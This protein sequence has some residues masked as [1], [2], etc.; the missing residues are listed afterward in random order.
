VG[1][2]AH[3]A[4]NAA[5]SLL[6]TN[7]RHR[8]QLREGGP[9]AA[10]DFA[11]RLLPLRLL[12]QALRHDLCFCWFADA[13]A[14]HAV[15]AFHAVGKP[16]VIVPGQYE[17]AWEPEAEYGLRIEN[18]NRWRKGMHAL[19]HADAVCA[20]SSFHRDRLI[21]AGAD[22]RRV[23]TIYHGFPRDFGSS[24]D[25]EAIVAT[26]AHFGSKQRIWH[27]DWRRSLG[28]PRWSLRHG[29]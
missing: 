17:I 21:E 11:D 29:S 27:K 2:D 25:K 23:H 9:G 16:V 8:R 3:H 13:H 28:P 19:K 5:N 22:S 10:G 1:Q 26:T 12:K 24:A 18:T 7:V 6:A 4:S 15:R 20:V 14:Y